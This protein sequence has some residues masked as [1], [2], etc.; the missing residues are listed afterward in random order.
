MG[1]SVT[2]MENAISKGL[3]EIGVMVEDSRF[4][5]KRIFDI[6]HDDLK[7]DL[8]HPFYDF[9]RSARIIARREGIHVNDAAKMIAQNPQLLLDIHD[10]KPGEAPP[11]AEK[12][13]EKSGKGKN[14][15]AQEPAAPPPLPE[16]TLPE[17]KFRKGFTL[18]D[19]AAS[20]RETLE[21]TGERPS[22]ADGP[23]LHGPLAGKYSWS[24]VN[25]K[26]SYLAKNNENFVHGSLAAFSNFILGPKQ[27]KVTAPAKKPEPKGPKFRKGFNIEDLKTSIQMSFDAT[28]RRPRL[29]DGM[30]AYGP[31]AGKFT[32]A[33]VNQKL[34]MAR[35]CHPDFAYASLKEISVAVLGIEEKPVAPVKE[36]LSLNAKNIFNLVA[37]E[38]A[39]TGQVPRTADLEKLGP[40]PISKVNKAFARAS[41][42]D[43]DN[44]TLAGHTPPK[45]LQEF[46]LV[47][48][49]AKIED[50]KL[51][52]AIPVSPHF[53]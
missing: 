1:A 31:F 40:F 43:I 2:M 4:L 21:K 6:M 12:L 30:I 41:L 45:S 18:K 25:Q 32:W 48:G 33:S 9:A 47:A 52:P 8:S 7:K 34:L 51:V 35:K 14:T 19:L 17:V 22:L 3:H 29:N 5:K 44:Y 24:A 26:L 50:R 11:V 27:V 10:L 20:L 49:L 42:P 36:R 37:A 23:V 28:K 39:K 15:P 53:G 38:I 16:D 13:K 46:M